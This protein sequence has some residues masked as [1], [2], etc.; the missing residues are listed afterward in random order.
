MA[1]T[2][3]KPLLRAL[4][5]RDGLICAWH[6]RDPRSDLCKPGTLVPQHRQGGMGGRNDKHRLSNVVWLDS[7]TNGAV[8]S[9]PLMQLEAYERGI[10]IR[11]ELDPE[12]TPITHAVHG[13]CLLND[14]GTIVPLTEKWW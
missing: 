12:R 3:P 14:D 8:E 2:T 11:G 9:D 13:K 4:E 7:F 10:K 6:G 1:D 5:A